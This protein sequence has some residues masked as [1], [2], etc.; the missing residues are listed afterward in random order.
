MVGDQRRRAHAGARLLGLDREDYF[1]SGR[2]EIVDD[3]HAVPPMEQLFGSWMRSVGL[4]FTA[5]KLGST[6]MRLPRVPVGQL[7]RSDRATR[8]ANL[9]TA[10][11]RSTDRR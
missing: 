9:A 8:T 1:A 4:N 3:C 10:R 2:T 11:L 6:T 7:P 5:A